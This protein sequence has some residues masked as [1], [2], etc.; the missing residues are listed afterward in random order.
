MWTLIKA[1]GDGMNNGGDYRELMLD[2]AS[3]IASEPENMG[4]IAPGSIAYL[5]DG[6]KTWR[7]NAEG[8]WT[9]IQAGGGGG[10]D[11]TISKLI[12]TE[13]TDAETETKEITA[14]MDYDEI[15][16]AINDEKTVFEAYFVEDGTEG[17]SGVTLIGLSEEASVKTG[18]FQVNMSGS[19][20]PPE[21]RYL[22]LSSTG[23]SDI[24][25]EA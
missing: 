24:T 13:S 9:L 18:V 21:P 7:K 8:V 5:V 19:Q 12:I 17:V 25:P 2:D 10:S 15:L 14:N 4:T 16:A 22:Q 20:I 3:D 1:G 11:M 23:W 6:S